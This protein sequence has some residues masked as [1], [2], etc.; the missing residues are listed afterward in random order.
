MR[1]GIDTGGTF[2][3]FVLVDDHGTIRRTHKRLSTPD[4][5]ARAVIEGLAHLL[6]QHGAVSNA[7]VVHGTTVATNALLEDKGASVAFVTTEGFEDTLHIAR[8]NR[9][10]LYALEPRRPQPPVSRDRCVGA[11]ERMRHDGTVLR[12]LTDEACRHIAERIAAMG[13]ESVAVSLLHSYANPVHEQRLAAA[14]ARRVPGVAVTV[15]HQLLPELREYERAATCVANASV[16]PVIVRYLSH[17]NDSLG[18]S[19][20]RVMASHGGALPVEAICR[21]P[22]QTVLSGPAGG[23]LGALAMARAADIERVIGFDMGGTSTDVTLCDTALSYTSDAVVG[24]LPVRL[25][26]IDIH[27]VGAGGGSLAWVDAGG[28]LRVGPQSAGADPGP[29]CYGRQ[30]PPLRAT[31]T[32]AHVVLG[33]LRGD[34]PLSG[35]LRLDVDAARQAVAGIAERLGVSVDR[36]AEGILRVADAAMARAIQRVSVQ[37]GHDVRD[38]TLLPFGGAGALHACRLAEVLGMRRVLVPLHPGL[39]SAVGMLTA[40]PRYVY[41]HAIMQQVVPGSPV[42]ASRLT[43]AMEHMQTLGKASL[44]GNGVS[45]REQRYELHV[46]LRYAGQSHELT[47]PLDDRTAETFGAEHERLY[48]YATSDRPIEIVAARLTALG[49]TPLLQLTSLEGGHGRRQ[50]GCVA[51]DA[52]APGDTLDGP[53]IVTEFSAT[54]VVPAGWR[55]SVHTTGQLIIEREV[56]A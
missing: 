29:A 4:D 46:D 1:V 20:L 26:M 33:N 6:S 52:L 30:H 14:L 28:A 16:A 18:G 23:A 43:E 51:R 7:D 22:V 34:H 54:T 39:L 37:R 50:S 49:P 48:G 13:V 31:V 53:G 2:T 19:G 25:P 44:A 8:Q 11:P 56:A 32:D 47:V 27:T 38:Y 10:E 5:P 15:S 21:V 36:A 40:P 55:L 42:A 17:L 3:D 24:A 41:S 12:A 45:E 35:D 9:P